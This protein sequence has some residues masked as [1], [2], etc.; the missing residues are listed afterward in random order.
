MKRVLKYKDALAGATLKRRRTFRT[1]QRKEKIIQVINNINMSLLTETSLQEIF[2]N[3]CE[4]LVEIDYT[5]S[6]I[7]MAEPDYTVRPVASCG[8]TGDY[9][10]KIKIRWD[11]VLEGRGPTGSAIRTGKI[12]IMPNIAEDPRFAPWREAALEKGYRSS[13]AIP[14]KI[15][16]EVI[17]ALNLYKKKAYAFDLEEL[18]EL[19]IIANEI[20]RIIY[21]FKH[22]K[23]LAESEERFRSIFQNAH[24]GIFIL[25]ANGSFIDANDSFYKMFSYSRKDLLETD[26]RT[27][28]F[29]EDVEKSYDYIYLA[30]KNGLFLPDYRIRMADG[31]E[32]WGDCNLTPFNIGEGQF[33]L[34][35]VRNITSQRLAEQKLE[36]EKGFSQDIIKSANI[37]I[38]GV[39]LRGEITIF[40]DMSEKVTGYRREELIGKKWLAIFQPEET[41]KQMLELF[42]NTVQGD[43]PAEYES[44]VLT[45][46]GRRRIIS[47]QNGIIKKSGKIAGAISFG[48]DIT[49]RKLAEEK[50]QHLQQT[51]E[52]IR[53]INQLIVRENNPDR[54]FQRACEILINTRHY[55]LVRIWL[56]DEATGLIHEAAHAASKD[57]NFQAPEFFES[58]MTISE[59]LAG[60]ICEAKKPLVF[61]HAGGNGEHT[62]IGAAIPLTQDDNFFGMMKV[63]TDDIDGFSEEELSLLSEVVGDITYALHTIDLRKRQEE[64][65]ERYRLA[66]ENMMAGFT[67]NE[68]IYDPG[69][70]MQNYRIIE[71]NRAAEE[72]TGISKKIASGNT[73]VEL[74]SGIK[75]HDLIGQL[76]LMLK[77]KGIY[78]NENFI[79]IHKD[80]N[81]I[82]D[83][84]CYCLSE[85]YFVIIFRDITRQK[86]TERDLI[87]SLEKLQKTI[88]DIVQ[89][90]ALTVETKDPYTAGHQQRVAMIACAIARELGLD[91]DQVE[92]IRVASILHDIG[93]IY[94]PAEILA[95]PGQLCEIEKDLVKKHPL[96]SYDILKKIEFPW[97]IAQITL[98]HHERINGSGYPFGLSGE[99]ICL[100]AKI[101]TVA[102]V[103]EAMAS[104]RPYRPA[105]GVAAALEE[106]TK[107]RGILYDEEVVD[108]C[109]LLFTKKGFII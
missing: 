27:F 85:K 6:W 54:L 106:I 5:M 30:F 72:V 1:L 84:V 109:N 73:R 35:I 34:C 74:F 101:L 51:L 97:Q 7:G 49:G 94:V 102:D 4:K 47:W 71:W 39:N 88:D 52:A 45:K 40:N 92:G 17:G 19:E 83:M 104:H 21:F 31:T 61:R 77:N 41:R 55:R 10:Q 2:N 43:I 36:E 46:D 18:Q 66:I 14:L 86:K 57:S 37:M 12:N 107:N 108:A 65:E 67:L 16:D 89:A 20:S 82:F 60:E 38:V 28:L 64:S 90:M 24:D 13:V 80:V 93:K 56:Y 32:V 69:G 53:N 79:Y 70:N 62:P 99:N 23:S 96:V 8:F 9:L 81:R 25:D 50:A 22:Q 59:E 78:K 87:Q 103:V 15:K 3:V 33:L 68:A 26:V 75:S 58:G 42:K 105:L 29:S 48:I 91:A 11:D 100:E 95:R 44:V 98:Q 76:D 63:Y